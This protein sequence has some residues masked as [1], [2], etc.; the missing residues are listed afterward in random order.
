MFYKCNGCGVGGW[1]DKIYYTSRDK[2]PSRFF[3][4]LFL[5]GTFSLFI[6]ARPPR[7]A[8]NAFFS[9]IALHCHHYHFF[10]Y[11]ILFCSHSLFL[12]DFSRGRLFCRL[13]ARLH[14]SYIGLYFFALSAQNG[15]ISSSPAMI[16]SSLSDKKYINPQ[17]RCI[18]ETC[19]RSLPMRFQWDRPLIWRPFHP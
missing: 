13:S 11:V 15:Y 1:V 3:S 12:Y 7:I 16:R 14:S 19:R 6:V 18:G 2:K 17:C 5:F 8:T 10:F 9:S 4:F